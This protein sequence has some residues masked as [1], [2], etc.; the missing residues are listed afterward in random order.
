M[1]AILDEMCRVKTP[2]DIKYSRFRDWCDH[3]THVVAE[4]TE[5]RTRVEAFDGMPEQ[6]SAEKRGPGRPRKVADVA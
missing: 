4:L 2:A 1:D 3:W 5:L 6:V